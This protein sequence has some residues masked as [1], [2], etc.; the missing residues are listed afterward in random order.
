M[1]KKQQDEGKQA[2]PSMKN[3]DIEQPLKGMNTDISPQA[4]LDG[5]Y[6]FALNA[7]NNTEEGQQGYL[8][9]EEG[10]FECMDLGHNPYVHIITYNQNTDL[11]L[12]DPAT[13]FPFFTSVQLTGTWKV[14]G[15]VYVGDDQIIA[16][17]TGEFVDDLTGNSYSLS[18]LIEFNIDSC[19]TKVLLTSDC[20]NFDINHQ[21]QGVHRIRK[22]CERNIYFTD[23]ENEPRQINLDSLD[24]YLNTGISPSSVFASTPGISFE[25][26]INIWDCKQ[27]RLFTL[28]EVPHIQYI[29]TDDSGGFNMK[30]GT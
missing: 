25:T 18:R 7:V 3:V 1:A 16:F 29:R 15:H 4:Q 13:G 14:I 24:S 17:L 2:T 28:V 22:G 30:P 11:P 10:T 12:I 6:R 19:D 9:T 20:L 26:S 5:T 21:I 23:N 27:F 8:S